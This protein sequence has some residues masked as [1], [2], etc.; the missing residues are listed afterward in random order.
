MKTH[1]L[2]RQAIKNYP[3]TP[4]TPIERTKALRRAW[5]A[6]I[7]KLRNETNRGWLLDQRQHRIT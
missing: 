4:Y 5:M 6:A 2:A 7:E 3:R 1:S